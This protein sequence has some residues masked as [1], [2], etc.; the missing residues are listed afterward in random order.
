MK[1]RLEDLQR[2]EPWEWPDDAEETL[3]SVL[4]EGGSS[5]E[6]LRAAATFAG[7]LSV[8]NDDLATA[9]L[10]IASD[11][12][13]SVALRGIAAM[14]LGPALDHATMFGFDDPQDV[15]ISEQTY[16][17]AIGTLRELFSNEDEPRE[18]RRR[19]LEASVRAPRPWHRDVVRQ[20]YA[21]E[22]PEWRRTAVFCMR[23]I[24][25]FEEQILQAIDG[26]DA[27]SRYHAVWA[28]GNW[29]LDTAWDHIAALVE[30]PETEKGLL[31]AAIGAAAS[32]RPKDVGVILVDLA[33]SA[34]EEIAAAATEALVMAQDPTEEELEEL[35]REEG[36]ELFL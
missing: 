17:R 35:C 22:E 13:R 12:G 16:Q 27:M 23:F 31:L 20:A 32:I 36:D 8:L 33:S 30:S 18:V 15:V 29:E 1:A 26:E 14:S 5:E 34:D 28:A 10:S 19:A 11:S 6:E 24:D 3:L 4:K 21:S 25:G 2:M 7:E 9:L